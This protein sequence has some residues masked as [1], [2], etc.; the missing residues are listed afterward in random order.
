MRIVDGYILNYF[1][2]FVGW[3]ATD[4]I[5]EACT[6]YDLH[7]GPNGFEVRTLKPGEPFTT[8]YKPNRINLNTDYVGKIVD[9]AIG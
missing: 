1:R 4:A 8:E 5:Q 6:K 7:D 2:A 3:Y 9:I